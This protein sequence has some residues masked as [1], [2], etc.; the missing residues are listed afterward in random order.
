MAKV[1]A[2]NPDEIVSSMQRELRQHSLE[3]AALRRFFLSMSGVCDALDFPPDD[4]EIM[5]LLSE[6]L[7]SI[8]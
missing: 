8:H 6:Q 5:Q 2:F 1:V 4:S 3:N 7:G